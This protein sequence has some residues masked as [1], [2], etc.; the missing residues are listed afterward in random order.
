M[1]FET[2]MSALRAAGDAERAENLTEKFGSG[3]YFGVP[4]QTL[5]TVARDWRAETDISVRLPLARAL[6][7]SGN[8]DAKIVAAK[9]LTQA[10]IKE[11]AD[12]WSQ[13]LTWLSE[14]NAWLVVDALASAG[15][16][17][18]SADLSRIETVLTLAQSER[19]LDRRAALLLTLPLAKITHQSVEEKS[20]IDDILPFLTH[21]LEDADKDVSRTADNW[22]RAL[23]K[24]DPKR[25]KMMRRVIQSR[26]SND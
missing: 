4:P 11:D 3:D 5:D 10:R 6:W 17:R 25:A 2:A 12:I 9:L 23:S 19:P 16:R 21:A 24:H 1:E 13:I 26:A 14:E 20:A 22:L 18:V 7:E 8:F 15:A